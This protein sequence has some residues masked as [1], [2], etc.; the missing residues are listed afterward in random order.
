M[1]IRVK[2]SRYSLG[3]ITFALAALWLFAHCVPVARADAVVIP[4]QITMYAGQALVQNAPGSLTRVA[5]GDG[6]MMQVK[7]LGDRQMVLIASKEGDTSLQLW[8]SDGSQRSVAVHIVVGNTDQVADLVRQLLGSGG[9]ISVNAVGGN[10]VLSGNNL[11]PSDVAHVTAIRKL[12]PQVLDF[13]SA[14]AVNMQPMVLMKV[15]I[16]EFDKTSLNQV[17]IQWDSV[18]AGPSGGLVHDW[19]TNPY[20]RV[21]SSGFNGVDGTGSNVILPTRV[22]GTASYFGIATSIGSQINL[23]E[24]DGKAWELA[25]PQLSARSGGT[26]DF[27]VGGQVPIPISNGVLGQVQVDYKDYGI[28][29]HIAPVVNS[30]GEIS[31]DLSTEISRIDPT[32]TV[33]GYPGFVT[34]RTETQVNVHEGQTIVISGL[35]D[36]QGSKD[37]DKFPGLGDLPVLGPLFRSRNFQAKRTE[38]VVFVTPIVVDAN[39]PD[40]KKEIEHSD[41]LRDDFRKTIG[42]DIVD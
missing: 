31:T 18:I 15:R 40:N 27:L 13:T 20:Y 12:Y 4:D 34:R 19:V 29:L 2:D 36:A 11:S 28:K 25:A 24:Q 38:L 22:P 42:S 3:F 10:V 16:M 41:H 17:G 9:P 1:D 5:V 23:L 37:Y 8:M 21:Q 14:N 35:V 32:V 6:K 7:V 39:S 30:D 33:Q 26:A